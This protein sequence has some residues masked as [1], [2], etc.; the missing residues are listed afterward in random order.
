MVVTKGN[1]NDLIDKN[2]KYNWRSLDPST[3][4]NTI[5]DPNCRINNSAFES[6][7]DNPQ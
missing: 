6:L 3:F 1:L 2:S 4:I 7:S 5:A